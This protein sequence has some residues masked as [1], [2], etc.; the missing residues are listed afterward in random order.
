MADKLINQLTNKSVL[1]SDYLAIADS[2]G[3]T[4]K[5]TVADVLGVGGRDWRNRQISS[6]SIIGTGNTNGS[7]QAIGIQAPLSYTGQVLLIENASTTTK[8]VASFDSN[9]FIVSN[10]NVNI[11][12]G[13]IDH[14]SLLNYSS[15][16]HID[17]STVSFTGTGHIS[18]GGNLTASRT[19]N[20]ITTTTPLPNKIPQTDLSGY[21][22]NFVKDMLY[23]QVASP[24]E[25]LPPS[26]VFFFYLPSRLANRKI[27]LVGGATYTSSGSFNVAISS[28][29]TNYGYIAGLS[30]TKEES[31]QSSYPNLPSAMSLMKI[32][33]GTHTGNPKGLDIWFEVS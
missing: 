7:Y 20:V 6:N 5:T 29:G 11:K 25:N 31:N 28:G 21:L 33:T 10:G 2:T 19:F 22:N 26:Y 16:K 27:T 4:G 24:E 1:T 8:G 12:P 15:N 23:I 30:T 32:Y 9:Y 17:H 18:G 13:G 3:V 14:D